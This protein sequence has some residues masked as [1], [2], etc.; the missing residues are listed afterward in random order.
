MTSKR[1]HDLLL[2]LEEGVAT[3][4][5]DIVRL[6]L[7]RGHEVTQAT[8]SRD[9]GRVGAVKVRRGT[10]TFYTLPDIAGRTAARDVEGELLEALANLAFSITPAA[11][12]VIVKTDPGHAPLVARAI[13]LGGVSEVAGTVA[14][15]D[16][17]FVATTS[18]EDA[19]RL[20]ARWVSGER[21]SS[22]VA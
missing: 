4:Q 5:G 2:I 16:T 10:R 1:R 6:L 21:E 15:D 20:A 14:G 22:E 19:Q 18:D 17:I 7:E 13:D 12:L 11:S 9:L 3:S 8:V